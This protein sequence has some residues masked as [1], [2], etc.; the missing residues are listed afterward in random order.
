MKIWHLFIFNIFWIIQKKTWIHGSDIIRIISKIFLIICVAKTDTFIE[1]RWLTTRAHHGYLNC[2][3][4]NIS[5]FQDMNKSQPKCQHK[6]NSTAPYFLYGISIH[7]VLI[8]LLVSVFF[9]VI[10]SQELNMMF[11]FSFELLI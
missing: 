7:T 3:Y 10:A 4:I 11:I 5:I 6:Y 8:S 1:H 2:I 9:I